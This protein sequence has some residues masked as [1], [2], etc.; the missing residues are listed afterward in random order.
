M[1]TGIV[2]MEGVVICAAIFGHVLIL[3]LF[4]PSARLTDYCNTLNNKL[5]GQSSEH[6]TSVEIS[7]AKSWLMS[8]CS[9]TCLSALLLASRVFAPLPM[10]RQLPIGVEDA[11]TPSRA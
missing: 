5:L 1:I 8:C 7:S 3:Y 11:E 10:T 2:G 4:C 9:R 6:Y